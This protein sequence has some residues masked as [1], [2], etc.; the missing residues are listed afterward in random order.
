MVKKLQEEGDDNA[1]DIEKFIADGIEIKGATDESHLLVDDD[2][3]D[4]N[5]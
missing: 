5:L 3:I 1:N 4:E 2:Q